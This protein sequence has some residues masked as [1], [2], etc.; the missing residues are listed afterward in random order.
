MKGLIDKIRGCF[1]STDSIDDG[2]IVDDCMLSVQLEREE[3]ALQLLNEK[4]AA[5]AMRK[6]F[7]R[8]ETFCHL[9]VED[10]ID[11]TDNV[12]VTRFFWSTGISTANIQQLTN[13]FLGD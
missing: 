13:E 6:K 12:A 3:T 1:R 8:K 5:I 7:S 9:M 4:V 2:T 11:Y 10:E